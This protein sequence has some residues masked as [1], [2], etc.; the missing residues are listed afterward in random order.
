MTEAPPQAGTGSD[1]R[2]EAPLG[3]LSAG[4]AAF[5]AL[6]HLR[7]HPVP[8][9]SLLLRLPIGRHRL[10]ARQRP[11]HGALLDGRPSADVAS[12][13]CGA[14]LRHGSRGARRGADDAQRAAELRHRG[15]PY[16]HAGRDRV[17]GTLRGDS[18]PLLSPPRLEL[19][20]QAIGAD[21]A[22]RTSSSLRICNRRT[23]GLERVG[24]RRTEREPKSERDPAPH[25][26][27]ERHPRCTL[28]R[29]ARVPW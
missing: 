16:R 27:D 25:R 14:A 24:S 21:T 7:S 22:R 29:R 12:V 8:P 18:S 5:A 13:P 10:G 11:R 6:P 19:S 23:R 26:T 20:S 2:D 9:A 4:R 1:S 28:P 17:R 15:R 3:G